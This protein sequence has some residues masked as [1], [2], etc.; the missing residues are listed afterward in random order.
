L[1]TSWTQNVRYFGELAKFKVAQTHTIMHCLKV[2]LEDLTGPNIDMAAMLLESCG[3]FLLRSE[4]T[5]ER[6]KAMVGSLQFSSDGN[7][8]EAGCRSS[9]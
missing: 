5:S 2:F 7:D 1:L 4:A 3:R 9:I 8:A 6:M